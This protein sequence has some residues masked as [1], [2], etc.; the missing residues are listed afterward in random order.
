VTRIQNGSAP[1]TW[2][3]RP[4]PLGV[5]WDG[6]GVNVAVWSD[7]AT[8]VEVCLFDSA[9]TETRVALQERNGPIWHGYLPGVAPGQ[10]YGLRADGPYLPAE[11]RRHNP[12]KLLMDPYAR[13]IAGDLRLEP[14]VFAYAG[15]DPLGTRR[16]SRDS[17]PFVP[18]CI[19]TGDAFPW[20]DDRLPRVPWSETVLY[21]MHVRGF[22]ALHPGVPPELRGTYAGLAHPAALEHLCRLGVTTVELLPIQSFVSETHLLQRGRTNYW[23]YNTLGFFAPHAAYAASNYPVAE[24]KAMVRALHSAGLEVVLDVVYN[25]TAEGGEGGP[26]LSLRGLDNAAYYRLSPVDRRYYRDSTGCG[27]TLDL[28]SAPALQLVLDSLRYWA[29]EMHVDG[30][31]FDLASSLSRGSAFLEAVGQDPVLRGLK[32]VAEPWDLESYEVGGFPWPWAEWNG[33]YRDAVRDAWHGRAPDLAELAT[34][35]SGS[36]DL[37][38]NRSP[39]ASI[40]LITV[41]DGFP[42]ADLVSYEQKHNEANGEQ[43]RDGSDDNRSRN[44]GVEGPTDDAAITES[45][46]RLR[47]AHLA[48]LL[49][50]AGVPLLLAGDELGRTQ[51]GNNNAYCQD[52]ELSWV[53]WPYDRRDPAGGDPMLPTLV[54]GLLDLRRRSPVLCRPTFFRGGPSTTR[55]LA[56]ISWFRPD[57]LE[58]TSADWTGAQTLLA[59]LSGHQIRARTERGDRLIDDSYLLVLHIGGDDV[60]VTLP[61]MPWA[62][63][64]LPLLDTAAE[65]LGGFPAE[66]GTAT[67]AGTALRTRAR[68]LQ[69]L[70]VIG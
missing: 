49:L 64:Y 50:S 66:T 65:D 57:G 19:V 33:R 67:R 44:G 24:F 25:H 2:P 23:G 3:G 15:G 13:A 18:R 36:S 12:S 39:Q 26:T 70:R 48:T 62:R 9:G 46:R 10:R 51:L 61:G 20:G 60:E 27:N 32:L 14:A 29:T 8:A 11:G 45:R 6:S 68:S 58:M 63:L 40:N 1:Q 54:R 37:Y 43:N 28:A 53:A 59:H 4:E 17:A 55:E 35:L 52:N 21:E 7:S 56:D 69:L 41:H 5:H 22:T 42:L 38:A 47:R 30:F 16:D 31:R 34:R